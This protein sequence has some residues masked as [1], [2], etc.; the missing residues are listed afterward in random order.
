MTAKTKRVFHIAKELNI[1]H[2]EILDFLKQRDIEIKT[3]K[4]PVSADIYDLILGE[5]SK[6]KKQIERF[7]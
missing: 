2:L 1:S 5:F 6:E 7:R 4:S 3:T